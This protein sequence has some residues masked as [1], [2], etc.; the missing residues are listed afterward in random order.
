MIFSISI[1]NTK[2]T[3]PNT[4]EESIEMN[5]MIVNSNSEE[6]AIGE[7]IKHNIEKYPSKDNWS[8]ADIVCI[9]IPN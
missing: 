8:I 7:A 6:A 3:N 4:F 5:V 2:W 9:Q 1:L